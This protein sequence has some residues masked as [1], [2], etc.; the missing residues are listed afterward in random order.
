ML[1]RNFRPNRWPAGTPQK[2]DQPNILGPLHAAY[3]D[4]DACPSLTFLIDHRETPA[5]AKFFHWAVDKRPE[6]ELFN[7]KKDSACLNNLAEDPHFKD[8]LKA[9]LAMLNEYLKSTN[10][11]RILDGGDIFETY[12]RYSRIRSFPAPE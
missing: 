6:I 10:D 5:Y 12:P 9:Q 8:I 11:P 3:H 7:I 1:I 2:Y 4:I